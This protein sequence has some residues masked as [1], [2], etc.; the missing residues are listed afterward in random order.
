VVQSRRPNRVR[1]KVGRRIVG[2][3]LFG[4]W[5]GVWNV[6]LVEKDLR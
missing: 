5:G 2:V 6:S 1:R 4:S 3:Y